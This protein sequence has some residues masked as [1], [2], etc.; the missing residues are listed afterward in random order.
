MLLSV[1]LLLS[2]P[3]LTLLYSPSFRRFHGLPLSLSTPYPVIFC[4]PSTPPLAL[5]PCLIAYIGLQ[6]V[7]PTNNLFVWIPRYMHCDTPPFP[8][9]IPLPPL[10]SP[11]FFPHPFSFL[12]I[13][14]PLFSTLP[15]PALTFAVP[16]PRP[17]TPCPFPLSNFAELWLDSNCQQQRSRLSCSRLS[18]ESL[19]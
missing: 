6:P 9:P 16:L 7:M 18:C 13:N 2:A 4:S 5:L 17:V 8:L 3:F 19:R 10:H 12:L 15:C 14:Q 1:P 11:H